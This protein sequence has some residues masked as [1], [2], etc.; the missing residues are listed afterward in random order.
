MPEVAPAAPT[1][2]TTP[3]TPPTPPASGADAPKAPA[4]AAAPTKTKLEQAAEVAERARQGAARARQREQ[5]F[6]QERAARE[7]AERQVSEM[8]A[9]LESASKAERE[10]A[11]LRGGMRENLFAVLEA[12]G[13]TPEQVVTYMRKAGT[14]EHEIQRAQAEFRKEL[15]A[16]DERIGA[17]EKQIAAREAETN[18]RVIE[19]RIQENIRFIKETVA[20]EAQFPNLSTLHHEPLI[21]LVNTTL[22]NA[23]KRTKRLDAEARGV[24]LE[25]GRGKWYDLDEVLAHL[26]STAFA[27][28][29]TGA[30]PP[31]DPPPPA[32]SAADDSQAASTRSSTDE[33]YE[34]PPNISEMPDE[35]QR[36]HFARYLKTRKKPAPP[37]D[38]EE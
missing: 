12:E 26:E 23:Y 13:V 35:E 34:L 32:G 36:E 8:Q 6:A 38:P 22:T 1:L 11:S 30:T 9:R 27:P 21:E 17:L 2:A 4:A 15:Q 3:A 24:P 14:P 19:Q 10:L 5:E 29:K 37:P 31:K 25:Q 20:D 18:Q 28:R 7:R 33:P 16:R